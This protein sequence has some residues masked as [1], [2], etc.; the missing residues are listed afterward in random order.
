MSERSRLSALYDEATEMYREK[1]GLGSGESD[2]SDAREWFK[3]RVSIA[4]ALDRGDKA[5]SGG[6]GTTRKGPTEEILAD[7]PDVA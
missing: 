3:I 1:A 2:G 7:F 4:A 5:G 6:K